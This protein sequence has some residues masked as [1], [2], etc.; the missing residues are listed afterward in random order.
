[1]ETR[2]G[3]TQGLCVEMISLI[4]SLISENEDMGLLCFGK[5]PFSI[6]PLNACLRKDK[7]FM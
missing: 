1:M 5:A 6:P 3:A 2:L 4:W 7:I